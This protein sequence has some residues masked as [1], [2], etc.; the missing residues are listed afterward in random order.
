MPK[1]PDFTALGDSPV[2]QPAS[3]IAVR[4]PVDR[5]RAVASALQAGAS[6]LQDASGI[7]AATKQRAAEIVEKANERQDMM[8]AEAALNRLQEQRLDLEQG[9]AGFRKVRGSSAV[10]QQFV[11][12]YRQKFDAA[13]QQIEDGL[14]N[15]NQRRMFQR[16]VPVAGLQ[17][18]SALLAHQ[19]R[20]TDQFNDRTEND[21]I[22]AARQQIFGAPTD[23]NALAAG[24]SRI[25]WAI[26]QKATRLGWADEVRAFTKAKYRE[27][28]YEDSAAVMVEQNPEGS[29]AL[30]NKRLGVGT[31][32]GKTGVAAF[33]HADPQKLLTLRHRA[34]S[35]VEQSRNRARAENEKRLKEAE[36]KYDEVLNFALTGQMVSPDYER[37]V[38]GRVA[39]TPFE[40]QARQVIA[41]SY[42]G[43]MH[44]SKPLA[45]Q[46]Q[47]LR[48]VDAQV[49]GGGTSAEQAKLVQHMRTITNTQ[50]EAYKENPWAAATRF[51]RQPPV[52][53]AQIASAGDVPQLVAQRLASISGVEVYAGRPVS[54]LQPNEA[55]AFAET[56]R[57]MPPEA[58]SEVLGQT[59]ALLTGTNGLPRLAALADQLD[60]QDRPLALA[61]KMGL[62]RTTAGR[63]ASTYVLRG[64]QALADKTVK[65][66]DSALAGWRAEIAKL[67]RGTLGDERAEQDVIDAAYYVR[68]ALDQEGVAAAGFKPMNASAENAVA[69]VIGRPLERAGVKT[70]MPR[71]MDERA[72]DERLRT[73]TPQKLRELAPAGQVYY[74]GTAIPVD[75][76]SLR[77]PEYGMKRDGAG[78]YVPIVRGAVVT[79]DPQGR[80]PLRLEVR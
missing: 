17:Y 79:V 8:M 76:L 61:L 74:R 31:E 27:K 50:R 21:T 2:P 58:R 44:G 39:G 16:R 66:D 13:R 18:R 62:D 67:V 41:L 23:P 48:A 36:S 1:L 69:M 40:P 29:L 10:G 19:A 75:Q 78:R 45:A 4:Q 25:D 28:V 57:A 46:E 52:P 56:L 7:A 71:G 34:A 70:F 6:D 77:L 30:L 55:K 35:V 47:D 32:A 72:F 59:G 64:Q 43:A 49:A 9:E 15:D 33:D 37:E 38:V 73:F 11:D 22:E 63:A 24:F 54:P 26:D 60:K 12:T 20:E 65:K 42:A 14:A 80:V 3:G 68:A 53:E 51:G 5:G